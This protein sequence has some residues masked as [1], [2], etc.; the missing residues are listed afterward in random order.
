[1]ESWEDVCVRCK[2][3]LK[4]FHRCCH[5][6]GEYYNWY[7]YIGINEPIKIVNDAQNL[8]QIQMNV[9]TEMSLSILL[10][11]LSQE[12]IRRYYKCFQVSRGTFRWCRLNY[13]LNLSSDIK[14]SRHIMNGFWEI[15]LLFFVMILARKF[16][17][18]K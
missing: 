13:S 10:F 9:L 1:M 7:F 14:M 5:F 2:C 4:T 18:R 17:F 6:V 11:S 12:D 8:G 3:V 16:L 15:L